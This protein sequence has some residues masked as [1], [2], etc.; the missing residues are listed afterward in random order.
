MVFVLLCF[1]K[2]DI[3]LLRIKLSQCL[4]WV[5]IIIVFGVIHTVNLVCIPSLLVCESCDD[6]LFV[7]SDDCCC[8]W[9]FCCSATARGV[10]TFVIWGTS[11]NSFGCFTFVSTTA[12]GYWT[13][14]QHIFSVYRLFLQ[15]VQIPLTLHLASLCPALLLFLRIFLN[16]LVM[17][18]LLSTCWL[19]CWRWWCFLPLSFTLLLYV[20]AAVY[21][22]SQVISQVLVLL[23]LLGVP[24]GPKSN[25][26]P[27]LHGRQ[28]FCLEIWVSS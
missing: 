21:L 5:P 3:T 14:Y 10:R 17:A 19:C 25:V 23:P 6:I 20:L 11:L 9:F 27:T 18:A 26:I 28:S 22:V 15:K 8:C 13:L 16:I 4:S 7:F 12:L 2:I 24:W 1:K